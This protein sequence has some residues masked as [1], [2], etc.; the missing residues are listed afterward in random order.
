[1]FCAKFEEELHSQGQNCDIWS[2]YPHDLWPLTFDSPKKSKSLMNICA[3][4]ENV[5]TGSDVRTVRNVDDLEATSNSQFTFHS[6]ISSVIKHRRWQQAN[7]AAI[8]SANQQLYLEPGGNHHV[9]WT[10]FVCRLAIQSISLL[11]IN[12]D[13]VEWGVK[14]I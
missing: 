7:T 5:R 2:Q 13:W 1:M 4:F 14:A 12:L 6:F 9:N 8:N 10:G 3:K 11:G